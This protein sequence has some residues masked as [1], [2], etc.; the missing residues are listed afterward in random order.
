M[1]DRSPERPGSVGREDSCHILERRP[2][3]AVAATAARMP[4]KAA[5]DN[6]AGV[7]AGHNQQ[8]AAHTEVVRRTGPGQEVVGHTGYFVAG[9]GRK[10]RF[11]RA[12]DHTAH[13]EEA[14]VRRGRLG[15][16]L[17]DR[18]DAVVAPAVRTGEVGTGRRAE[19][20]LVAHSGRNRAAGTVAVPEL[21]QVQGTGMEPL[22]RIRRWVGRPREGV[23]RTPEELA[24]RS[25][26]VG[27][28]WR[29]KLSG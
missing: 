9:S 3:E 8:V 12:V 25:R 11:V 23:R 28:S 20:R 10:E 22:E 13:S 24:D 27:N 7:A 4:D 16:A 1:R 6:L 29:F 19:H 15:R 14:A 18:I 5:E 2:G 21:A 17:A 26:V